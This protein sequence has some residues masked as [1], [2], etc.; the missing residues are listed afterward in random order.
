V[1][2]VTIRAIMLHVDLRYNERGIFYNVM[3]KLHGLKTLLWFHKHA[4][5][6]E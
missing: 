4:M 3:V 2:H 5:L 1:G 6:Q